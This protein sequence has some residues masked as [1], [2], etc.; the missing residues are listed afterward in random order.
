MHYI[1]ALGNGLENLK[2]NAI[3]LTIESKMN[4]IAAV[5]L[6][7]KGIGQK[8]I[9]SGGYTKEEQSEAGKM[10]EFIKRQFNDIPLDDIILD[11][12]SIDTAD[13]A[14]KVKKILPEGSKFVL[15]SFGYHLKRAKRIFNNFG[16]H[17][18]KVFASE[19]VLK[20][21]SPKYDYIL[22]KF[23]WKRKIIKLQREI[24]CLFLV[25][26]IDPKG[27]ILRVVTSNSRGN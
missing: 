13:N 2:D 24:L 5:V 14:S 20:Q 16:L 21:E 25:H 26:T 1:V 6:Y 19:K 22:Q 7:K 15:I 8:I 12:G 17:A 11:E 9:F 23:N 27:K 18:E 10:L 4:A 3:D